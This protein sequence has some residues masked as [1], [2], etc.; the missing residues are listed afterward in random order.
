MRYPNIIPLLALLILFGCKKESPPSKP[1]PTGFKMEII[2]GNNQSDS[3]GHTLKDSII[4]RVTNN[5]KLLTNGYLRFT[6]SGC[7]VNVPTEVPI[8]TGIGFFKWQLSGVIGA[9][10]LKV[11][12]LDSAR[13]VR[14]SLTVTAHAAM[15]LHGW[16]PSPCMASYN[17]VKTF[18]RLKT[19]KLFALFFNSDFLFSSDDNG[20]SW[21]KLPEIEGHYPIVNIIAAPDDGLFILTQGNGI[22]YSP[23]GG[24]TWVARNNGMANFRF[25]DDLSISP[26]GK[27]FASDHPNGRRYITTD[28]GVNWN[29]TDLG[30][31]EQPNGNNYFIDNFSTLRVTTDGGL[32]YKYVSVFPVTT[33]VVLE[34]ID[35]KGN[36]YVSKSTN[37]NNLAL[38]RSTD[39][40][41]TFTAV[42]AATY[43]QGIPLG[44]GQMTE[45]NGTFYFY[46]YGSG[47]IKTSDFKTFTNISPAFTEQSRSYILTRNN[48]LVIGLY[49]GSIYYY[50]P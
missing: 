11:I 45:Q 38:C 4:V 14:D 24:K 40:G 31:F 27:I 47:L 3:I 50:L 43:V 41:L 18:C 10:Q 23:D 16:Q 34:F 19:G 6:G 37:Y 32:S 8:N 28:D 39:N 15:P 35:V 44:L 7:D 1:V 30:I 26:L 21:H 29:T 17:G 49:Y 5:S 9:Q 13:V 25:T 2:K 42:Y 46:V 20:I 33:G 12:L 48:Q 22:Q 36:I